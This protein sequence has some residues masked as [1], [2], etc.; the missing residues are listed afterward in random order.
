MFYMSKLCFVICYIKVIYVDRKYPSMMYMY[1]SI[2]GGM[3]HRCTDT[4]SHAIHESIH[5]YWNRW[6][7]IL[8]NLYNAE[9][10]YWLYYRLLTRYLLIAFFIQTCSIWPIRPCETNLGMLQRLCIAHVNWSMRTVDAW[11][12]QSGWVK[13]LNLID[14]TK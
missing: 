9:R 3:I 7:V 10:Y 11:I 8:H 5:S 2:R 4:S 14:G 1:D 6:I 12:G 13:H